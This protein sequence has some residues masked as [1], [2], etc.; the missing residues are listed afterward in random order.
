DNRVMALVGGTVAEATAAASISLRPM[1]FSGEI[2]YAEIAR[3]VA[4]IGSD[5]PDVI[6][7][8]GGGKTI[9]TGKMAARETGAA[10]VSVP[11][12]ASNDAPTSHIA[13]IYDA[14]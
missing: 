7:A 3:L 4:L 1:E 5:Q 2:T 8:A 13:V 12:V 14:D 11:T 9:D 6:V 10:F